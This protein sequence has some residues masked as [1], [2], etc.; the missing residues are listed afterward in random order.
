[1]DKLEEIFRLQD[2]LNKRIGVDTGALD[3][4]GKAEWVLNYTR[5]LQQETAELIDSVPWKWWAK[6][7]KFDE[8]NA[9]VEVVDLFHFLVSLAQ[10]LGMSAQDVY[11]AYAKKNKVNHNRQD[12][13]YSA[14]NEDDSRHI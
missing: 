9:R 11:D 2:E 3:E 5:A 8:Q 13:G 10:V 12:S 1:M 6:Y 4:K 14:K 7:Q